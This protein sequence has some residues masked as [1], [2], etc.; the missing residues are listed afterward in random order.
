MNNSDEFFL[1]QMKGVS[2]IKK[3]EQDKKRK[4]KFKL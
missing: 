3:K 2:P 1:K 4:S